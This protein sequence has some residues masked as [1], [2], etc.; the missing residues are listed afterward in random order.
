MFVK[1]PYRCECAI[2]LHDKNIRKVRGIAQ[3]NALPGKTAVHLVLGMVNGKIRET[4][5][6]A[7]KCWTAN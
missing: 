2:R 4:V 6:R 3:F 5:R 7:P 1:E